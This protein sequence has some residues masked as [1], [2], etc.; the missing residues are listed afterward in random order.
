[1]WNNWPFTLSPLT[2]TFYQTLLS[3]P[4]VHFDPNEVGFSYE[5]I[6]WGALKLYITIS[7]PL[8]LLTFLAWISMFWWEGK[9]VAKRYQMVETKSVA[10]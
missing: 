10:A 8:M 3:T 6:G 5:N 2:E 4:V 7:L 1:M 9:R